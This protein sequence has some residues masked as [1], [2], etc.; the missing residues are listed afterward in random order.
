M[1]EMPSFENIQKSLI[2]GMFGII[3]INQIKN[4]N[5]EGVRLQGFKHNPNIGSKL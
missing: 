3:F 4:K 1:Q 5:P 2:I